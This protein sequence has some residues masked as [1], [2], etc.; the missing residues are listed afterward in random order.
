MNYTTK[1]NNGHKYASCYVRIWDD[2]TVEL[3]FKRAD[4]KMYED[5]MEFKQ[6]NGSYR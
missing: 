5:K 1:T 4:K 6:K 2:N 3:V